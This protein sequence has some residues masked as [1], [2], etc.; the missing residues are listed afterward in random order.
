MIILFCWYTFYFYLTLICKLLSTPLPPGFCTQPQWNW[1]FAR[2]ITDQIYNTKCQV[3][4]TGLGFKKKGLIGVTWQQIRVGRS[5]FNLIYFNNFESKPSFF[6]LFFLLF[7]KNTIIFL[8]GANSR[9]LIFCLFHYE[10][11]VGTVGLWTLF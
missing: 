9:P 4:R 11:S 8:F 5:P 1:L 3:F 2:D 6:G 7:T 10:N